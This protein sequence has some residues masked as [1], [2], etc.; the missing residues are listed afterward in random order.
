MGELVDQCTTSQRM[1]GI[2]SMILS[3]I[4]MILG[5]WWG[6]H[7]NS[8]HT[9]WLDGFNNC[10]LHAVLMILGM[11][12]CY[13]QALMSFRVLHDFGHAFAK[14]FHFLSH[15]FTVGLMIAALYYII[16]WHNGKNLGHLSSMHSWLGL[17]LVFVYFQNW[18]LGIV[19]FGLGDRIP[20]EWK[21][22]YLPSHR[23]LGIVGLLLAA[24]VMQTGI[25]QK[26][27]ID[28]TSGCFYIFTDDEEKNNP[29][30]GYTEI[31]AG[32]RASFGI[33]LIII[34]NTIVALFALWQFPIDSNKVEA[35]QEYQNGQKPEFELIPQHQQLNP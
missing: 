24:V 14:G 34:L 13:T 2:L 18:V 16:K 6:S 8:N 35:R 15:S 32:C 10:T 4:A 29:A 20:L 30:A 23:F 3:S 27:W 19:S 1:A 31:G 28:G 12:F 26:N 11:C 25:A 33:G 7:E 5:F 22:K 9:G 21:K 17:I